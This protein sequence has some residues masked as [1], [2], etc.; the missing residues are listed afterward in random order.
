[1]VAMPVGRPACMFYSLCN[2]FA[3][4][5][6]DPRSQAATFVSESLM[7]L[8]LSSGLAGMLPTVFI[9]CLIFSRPMST[10]MV[11]YGLILVHCLLC[12][13]VNTLRLSSAPFVV[14]AGC[15]FSRVRQGQLF[16]NWWQGHGQ[17]LAHLVQLMQLSGWTSSLLLPHT[18][19]ALHNYV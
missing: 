14:F 13:G 9:F 3:T 10:A 18:A 4:E 6:P 15:D 17:I 1:M 2:A 19:R 12:L 7:P 16:D 5:I 8:R 11:I